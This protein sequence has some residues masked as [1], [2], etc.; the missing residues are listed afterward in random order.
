MAAALTGAAA[1]G[2][3]GGV[4]A[5]MPKM[6]GMTA[7]AISMM[8]VPPTMGVMTR[9]SHESRQASRNWNSADAMTSVASRGGPP[10][11]RAV[12]HTAVKVPDV[13]IKRI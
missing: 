3:P 5:S 10:L 12:T 4:F 6:M 7:T 9:R 11:T 8:T 1:A 2:A 13:P